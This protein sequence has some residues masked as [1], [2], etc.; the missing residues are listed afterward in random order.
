M[1][2]N[3]PNVLS[4]SDYF[5]RES[6]RKHCLVLEYC[7]RGS[8]KDNFLEVFEWPDI[9]KVEI[10]YQI[11]MGIN[12]LHEKDV[13]HRDIKPG[14]I[15]FDENFQI[16]VCDFG[17]CR[18]DTDVEKSVEVGSPLYRDPNVESKKYT[19][20]CDIYSTGITFDTIFRKTCIF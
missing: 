17:F 12:A 20:K 9:R 6:H 16:K 2:V 15:L 1:T 18:T 5:Y 10:C 11:A 8:L 7:S 19:K 4:C 13:M 3:H 14:N